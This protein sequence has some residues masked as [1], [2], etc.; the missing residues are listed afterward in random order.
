MGQWIFQI[1]SNPINSI[2]VDKFDYLVRDTNAVGLKLSFDYSRII[3]E[4]MVINNTICY[5]YECNEDIYHMFFLR[6]RLHRQIY[7]DKTAKAI[8]IL[9]VKLMIEINRVI[10]FSEYLL[11]A[12]KMIELI[13]SFIWHQNS[14]PVIKDLINAINTRNLPKLIY[15]D[16]SISDKSINL[17]KSIGLNESKFILSSYEV[18]KFKVGYVGG[19]SNPLNH[20]TFYDSKTGLIVQEKKITGDSDS[21]KPVKFYKGS[22]FHSFSLLINQKHQEYFYRIYCTDLSLYNEFISYFDSMQ[23]INDE[24]TKESFD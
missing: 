7:N 14:T 15:Q 16:I 1:I 22:T 19:K 5:S 18:I 9:I 24:T 23:T 2:D 10:S 3:N 8:E 13:D 17:E 6:Y 21:M 12:E 4:C 20:I 11:D